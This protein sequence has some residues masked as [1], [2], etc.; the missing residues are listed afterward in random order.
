[1]TEATP[2]RNLE[3]RREAAL[4][5]GH[6][7]E[8]LSPAQVAERVPMLRLPADCMLNLLKTPPGNFM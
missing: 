3:A 8:F 7:A 6:E 2:L 1:M 4:E 5:F